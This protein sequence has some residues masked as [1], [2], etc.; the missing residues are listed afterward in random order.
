[1]PYFVGWACGLCL[2]A[3]VDRETLFLPSKLVRLCASVTG[4]L[5]LAAALATSEWDYLEKSVVCAL[6]ASAGYGAWAFLRPNNLGLGDARMAGLVAFGVGT[7]S[8][9]G[10]VVALACAPVAAAGLSRFR[11]APVALGPF[12]ALAGIAVVVASAV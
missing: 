8:P 11:R 9:G 2:L 12:L 7:V 4:S 3:I 10:C 5:L 6:I 1:V